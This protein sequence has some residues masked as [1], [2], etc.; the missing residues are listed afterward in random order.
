MPR[1]EEEQRAWEE[2][3]HDRINKIRHERSKKDGHR[4]WLQWSRWQRE[5]QDAEEEE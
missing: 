4:N 5:E 1:T 3:I 2:A